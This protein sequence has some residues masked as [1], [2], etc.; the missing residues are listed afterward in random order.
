LY[1][2]LAFEGYEDAGTQALYRLYSEA[3]ELM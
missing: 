3:M 1:Q 2:E